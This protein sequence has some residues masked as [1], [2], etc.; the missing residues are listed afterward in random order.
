[1]HV[2]QNLKKNIFGCLKKL[3]RIVSVVWKVEMCYYYYYFKEF[4]EIGTFSIIL[5]NFCQFT[6]F[7]FLFSLPLKRTIRNKFCVVFKIHYFMKIAPII[8]DCC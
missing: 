6:K 7:S 1:M 5:E 3:Q 4:E 8:K 2:L